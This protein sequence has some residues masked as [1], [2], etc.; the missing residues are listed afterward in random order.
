MVCQEFERGDESRRR[1]AEFPIH[2]FNMGRF[3]G[4]CQM[5]AVPSQQNVT[6]MDGGGSQMKGVQ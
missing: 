3:A 4:I 2:S 5:N 1:E 6:A